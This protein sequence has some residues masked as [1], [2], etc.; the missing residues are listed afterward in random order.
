MGATEGN[1][2]LGKLVSLGL[3]GA[4]LVHSAPAHAEDFTAGVVMSNMSPEDRYTFV[5]GIVEGLA[6]ARYVKD[7]KDTA[8]RSCI[9]NWFY[10]DR[11]NLEK[12]YAGF[13]RYPGALPG[14]VV[15]AL[16]SV[17]CGV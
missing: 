14:A 4:S 12:I 9:Y 5:A 16:V 6:H 15:G 8:G 11:A 2:K 7:N 17:D 3:V 1:S 13:E 10:D